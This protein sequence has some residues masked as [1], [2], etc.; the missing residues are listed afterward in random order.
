M[1]D[2]SWIYIAG[3]YSLGDPV[4]NTRTVIDVAERMVPFDVMPIIPHLTL[5]WDII[6]PKR[7]RFWY[8]YTLQ[9]LRRCDALYRVPGESAG[10]DLEV[11]WALKHNMPVFY[12]WSEFV[13]WRKC[14]G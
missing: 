13:K 8:E 10:A 7:P 14:F 11:E 3:P 5:L 12:D 6:H 2:K 9:I 1:L 4:Q